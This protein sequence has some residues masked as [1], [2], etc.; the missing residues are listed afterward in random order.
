MKR[1]LEEGRRKRGVEGDAEVVG[2]KSKKRKA[3]KDEGKG[4]SVGW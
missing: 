4:N 3:E 1:L 2:K